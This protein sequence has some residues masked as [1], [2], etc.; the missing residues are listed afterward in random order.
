MTWQDSGK[1]GLSKQTF[2]ALI[3]TNYAI[4]ELSLDLLTEG[5]DYVLTGRLQSDPLER[6]FSH[7][8]QLSG[9]RFLVSLQEVIRSESIIKLKSLLK[10]NIDITS[11]SI[12]GHSNSS[13]YDFTRNM[14]I[15]DYDHLQLTDASQ[16]V[17]VYISGYISL[18]LSEHTHCPVCLSSLNN[19]LISSEYVSNLNQGGLT[20]PCTSLQHFVLSAFCLLEVS[21]KEIR[22]SR[23]PWKSL[24]QTLL[25]IA[26]V[27]WDS[28]FACVDHSEKSKE[29]VNKCVS[30]IYFNNLRKQVWE[31][32]RKDQVT[33]FK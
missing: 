19:N 18:K 22:N 14:L 7:Y 29:S 3:Q 25:S 15:N 17:A 13:I 32:R 2:K 1:F 27:E 6:R 21:E 9:G 12:T 10:R 28:S 23:F 31:T 24:A 8:R 20:L 11:L 30:N 4:S 5:Y 33:A 26:T 16:Q